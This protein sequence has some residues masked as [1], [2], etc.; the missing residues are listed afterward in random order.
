MTDHFQE[1]VNCNRCGTWIPRGEPLCSECI[2]TIAMHVRIC[3]AEEPPKEGFV[4]P[5]RCCGVRYRANA[6]R[7]L[8]FCDA[9]YLVIKKELDTTAEK[10]NQEPASVWGSNISLKGTADVETVENELFL[11]DSESEGSNPTIYS[12][13]SVGPSPTA[14]ATAE[15]IAIFESTLDSA[16]AAAAV[17]FSD[18]N[19]PKDPLEGHMSPRDV[20]EIIADLEKLINF[21]K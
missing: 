10:S 6:G 3:P 2:K 1:P 17:N 7:E 18:K 4:V 12:Y 13:E 19:A 20:A 16:N 8:R 14:E 9:C 15:S 21:V 11:N 5:C